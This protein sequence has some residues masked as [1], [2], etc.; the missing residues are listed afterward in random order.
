MA[1]PNQQPDNQPKEQSL[2]GGI[3]KDCFDTI[4]VPKSKEILTNM[5]TDGVY[6]CADFVS[7]VARRRVW[8]DNQPLQTKPPGSTSIHTPYASRY[9]Q[10]QQGR[11]QQVQP[12]MQ[13]IGNRSSTKIEYVVF[14]DQSTAENMRTYLVAQ[15]QKFG[16]VTVSAFY[17]KYNDLTE[18]VVDPNDPTK[19]TES[20]LL[21]PIYNDFNYGWSRVEDIHYVRNRDGYWFNLPAPVLVIQGT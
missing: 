7:N 10:T 4:L 20:R 2:F 21:T 1:D 18:S 13:N 9:G 3:L 14:K 5:L 19:N 15:I 16:Y 17:Q 11:P 12:R 8:K 6:A